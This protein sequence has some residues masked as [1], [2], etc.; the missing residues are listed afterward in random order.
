M[1]KLVYKVCVKPFDDFFANCIVNAYASI[2]TYYDDSY[3]DAV[4]TN[5]YEHVFSD[6]EGLFFP[7]T[8]YTKTHY[9]RL[10]SLFSFD[11]RKFGNINNCANEVR[12]LIRDKTYVF[13]C[14]DLYYWNQYGGL[15]K[16][17]H[18]SHAS[19][20][21]GFDD[22]GNFYALEDDLG[23]TVKYYIHTF[24]LCQEKFAIWG[25]HEMN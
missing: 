22:S 21:T 2:L 10:K 8:D 19:L 18:A 12:Q 15:F 9:N 25:L 24:W 1:E 16:N 3:R 6:Y 5:C 7:Y 20:V 23:Y 14:V 17:T 11:F 13:V 4:I